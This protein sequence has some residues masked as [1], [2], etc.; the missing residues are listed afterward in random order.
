MP[1][2]DKEI[3]EV[4][5]IPR[6]TLHSWKNGS[7]YTKLLYAILKNMSTAEL[8]D[9]REIAEKTFN[10]LIVRR[11]RLYQMLY[12][13][14]FKITQKVTG[15]TQIIKGINIAN[16]DDI[17]ILEYLPE[18]NQPIHAHYI[19]KSVHNA[20]SARRFLSNVFE[21]IMERED[22]KGRNLVLH[23]YGTN[24]K[25]TIY[26]PPTDKELVVRKHDLQEALGTT[27]ELVILND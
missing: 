7:G 6:L 14:K 8:E 13:K 17:L 10:L 4:I 12:E 5:G 21:T 19:L 1:Q 9:K 23:L 16:K 20:A 3:T 24:L 25:P 18:T 2:T 22:A 15:R 11:E 26:T 27:K